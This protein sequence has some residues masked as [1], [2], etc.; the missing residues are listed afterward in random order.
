MSETWF[1]FKIHGWMMWTAW[2]VL[3]LVQFASNRYLKGTLYGKHMWIHRIIGTAIMLITLIFGYYAW[4]KLSF[5]ILPNW[6]SYF[7]FPIFFGV[8]LVAIGGIITRSYLRRS[9]W[10]TARALQIKRGHQIFGL[11][12]ILF[13]QAAVASGIYYYRINSQHQFDLPLEWISTV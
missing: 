1:N 10:N 3:S 5:K 13:G 9:V 2:S 11:L 7:V 4:Q 8:P 6:H 12:L